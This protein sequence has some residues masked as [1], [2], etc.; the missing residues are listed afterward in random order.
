MDLLS[1]LSLPRIVFTIIPDAFAAY[2]I[3]MYRKD[4]DTRK[5]M[6]AI[7]F[8]FLAG[9]SALQIVTLPSSYFF[10]GNFISFEFYPMVI[11]AL[12][13]LFFEIRKQ[14]TFHSSLRIFYS[15]LLAISIMIFIPYNFS[16][17]S[18]LIVDALGLCALAAAS[19]L[20]VKKAEL[21]HVLILLAVSSF[22]GYGLGWTFNLGLAFIFLSYTF[23][24]IFVALTLSFVTND[25]KSSIASIFRVT[26]KLNEAAER[27]RELKLE[28]KTVFESA[29]D[30]L[31]VINPETGLIVDCNVE[32][33][34]L[35]DR[36]KQEIIGK[37][38]EILF[39]IKEGTSIAQIIRKTMHETSKPIETQVVTE[40]GEIKE[41]AIK[42]SGVEQGGKK[43][44]VSIFRDITEQ[45]DA[46]KKLQANQE[47]IELVNE[48]LRVVGS[49]TRHDVRNKLS[50][51]NAYSYL[52]KKKHPDQ[53]D[54]V[55]G[56]EKMEQAVKQAQKIFDFAQSYEKLGVEELGDVDV[57]VA[58]NDAVTMFSNLPFKVVNNCEG[59]TVLA[60]SFLRQFVYN[61]IDNTAK[62]GKTTTTV[63]ISYEKTSEDNLILIYEDDG[64]GIP[65]DHRS[66][67]FKQGFSTGGSTGF[68]LFL[69]KRMI[70]VYGW[71]IQETG[72]AG[73]GA[74]FVIKIPKTNKASRL[75]FRIQSSISCGV[76]LSPTFDQTDQ[77]M[78]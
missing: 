47:R 41:V 34:N 5:V 50:V 39:P 43:F 35:V 17:V 22:L 77:L 55:E 11:T 69:S 73:K 49:L 42:T 48:K 19:F 37:N 21:S 63:K 61:L 6:A 33:T 20:F 56:L 53:A 57:A 68:G 1:V 38:Q 3:Y 70:E 72:D 14:E 62:Y 54:T 4:K 45:K 18:T 27:L 74:R 58:V 66:Q 7:S 9:S 13:I 26:E 67:L 59:L 2:F 12:L 10:F 71:T 65:S 8:I 64:V 60:D 28:Y 16:Q 40:K 32:A 51:I 23:G 44:L 75:N 76:E 30:A 15:S 31:F 25:D 29:N 78:H 24:F 46:E 52:I 36:A